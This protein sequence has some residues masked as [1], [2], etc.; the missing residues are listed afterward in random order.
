MVS[1]HYSSAKGN[2]SSWRSVWL[3]GQGKIYKD[4]SGMAFGVK[5]PKNVF[6]KKHEAYH[7]NIGSKLK[8][9]PMAKG[10]TI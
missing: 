1:N 9:L 4:E 10:G 3:Q 8:E 2:R 7:K 5:K 6:F